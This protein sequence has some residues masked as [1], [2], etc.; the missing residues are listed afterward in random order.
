MEWT[1]RFAM[2]LLITVEFLDELPL[3]M[4]VGS[5]PTCFLDNRVS[6]RNKNKLLGRIVGLG[7]PV[8]LNNSLITIVVNLRQENITL[9]QF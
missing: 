4:N 5:V 1:Y 6:R 3:F 8:T 7:I 9:D 2:Q